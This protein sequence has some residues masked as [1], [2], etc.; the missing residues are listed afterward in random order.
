MASQSL[1]RHDVLVEQPQILW[2]KTNHNYLLR[3]M[4]IYIYMYIFYSLYSSVIPYGE[5]KNNKKNSSGA[6]QR[7]GGLI[8][9]V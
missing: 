4:Y 1:D 9:S 7:G 2:D 8:S 3:I 6:T 5:N